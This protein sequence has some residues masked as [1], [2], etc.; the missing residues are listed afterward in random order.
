MYDLNLI[1]IK[2]VIHNHIFMLTNNLFLLVVVNSGVVQMTYLNGA[3][4]SNDSM[5]INGMR[6]M[7]PLG[8]KGEKSIIWK[9]HLWFLR[10]C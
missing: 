2:V 4:T 8:D 9:N 10:N 5:K 3:I 7:L 1:L 6:E